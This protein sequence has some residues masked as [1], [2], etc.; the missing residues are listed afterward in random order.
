[1]VPVFDV[2]PYLDRCL[3]SVVDQ[4][5]QPGSLEVIVVDDGST[6]GSRAIAEAWAQRHPA[7]TVVAQENRGLGAARNAGI[8]RARG[9]YLLFLDSDDYLAS[10]V[11]G[12]L[13]ETMRR[14]D[15]RLLGFEIRPVTPDNDARAPRSYAEPIDESS[16][17]S[18]IDYI[19]SRSHTKEACGYLYQRAFLES[20][21]L[22]F[23]EGV[24]LE[25]IVFTATTLSLADR[26]AWSSQDVYRYVQRAG[27]I[28]QR[29]DDPHIESMT[30]GLEG[31]VVGLEA[32]QQR[33]IREGF[34]TE[35]YLAQLETAQQGYVFFL[36]ARL[37]RSTLPLR[38]TLPRLIE[39]FRAIGAY[40]FTAF[41]GSDFPGRRYSL[42]ARVFEHPPLLWVFAGFVRAV[43]IT[44]R[45][46]HRLA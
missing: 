22:R 14:L 27:S 25:D 8:R 13:I 41:P 7:V 44:R 30:S 20:K 42:L 32:L 23:P 33:S 45:S 39:R 29:R 1:V 18:G 40:P 37:V 43:G 24:L 26:V 35:P 46:L 5:L 12:P 3:A 31:V 19:A 38:P 10:G 15:L 2:E 21:Q 6:D 11:L 4:H 28:M 17:M 34:A 36:I 9:S 16:V